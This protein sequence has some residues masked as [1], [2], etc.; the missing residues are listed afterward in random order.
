MSCMPT[1]VLVR[2]TDTSSR[3]CEPSV[4]RFSCTTASS[5]S[6][7]VAGHFTPFPPIWLRASLLSGHATWWHLEY[8]RRKALVPRPQ[9]DKG[10]N[11]PV[12]HVL[13]QTVADA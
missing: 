4:S 6:A 11:G 7:I 3:T 9:S 8:L 2:T 1:A 5:I 12:R 13:D 10:H